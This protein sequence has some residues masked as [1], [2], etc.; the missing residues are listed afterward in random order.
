MK[1]PQNLKEGDDF[2]PLG[3]LAFFL[4]KWKL[5]YKTTLLFIVNDSGSDIK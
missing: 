4:L 1:E 3:T 2:L 5:A